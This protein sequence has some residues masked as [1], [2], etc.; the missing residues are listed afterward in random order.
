MSTY[1]L[2]TNYYLAV[3]RL[4]V[5]QHLI[6]KNFTQQYVKKFKTHCFL[7]THCL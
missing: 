3:L 4:Q 5:T 1:L 2:N 6:F 7:K